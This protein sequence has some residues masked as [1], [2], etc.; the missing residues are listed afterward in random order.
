MI[1]LGNCTVGQRLE[2]N[3]VGAEDDGWEGESSLF[4]SFTTY[5]E[6]EGIGAYMLMKTSWNGWMRGDKGV[7][8]N[9]LYIYIYFSV[10]GR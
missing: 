1:G 10:K 5:D 3:Y 7:G 2:M 4:I 6:L 8:L 9:R